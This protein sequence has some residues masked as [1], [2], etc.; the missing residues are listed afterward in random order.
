MVVL[1]LAGGGLT[2]TDWL[3][4]SVLAILLVVTPIPP[5]QLAQRG[6]GE[7]TSVF[8]LAVVAPALGQ[9]LQSGAIHSITAVLTFPLFLLALSAVLAGGLERFAADVHFNRKTIL[10]RLGW[11]TSMVIH[12]VSILLAFIILLSSSWMGVPARLGLFACLALPVGLF[13]LWLVYKLG[14]GAPP[15]WKLIRFISLATPALT[16]Y[17][18]IFNLWLG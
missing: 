14:Q 3:V 1:L 8:I 2:M 5:I 4:V 17:L 9:S 12:S 7:L 13:Q 6:V 11:Q 16:V 10:T 15:F 18:L